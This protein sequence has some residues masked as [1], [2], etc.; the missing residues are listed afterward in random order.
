[1]EAEL[2]ERMRVKEGENEAQERY[3]VYSLYWYTRTNADAKSA[4]R[5]RERECER[6]E[7]RLDRLARQIEMQKK[8]EAEREE[9]REMLSRCVL[10]FMSMCIICR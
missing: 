7:E 4:A 2:R 5:A 6:K 10:L 9:M 1:M 8:I 3:S